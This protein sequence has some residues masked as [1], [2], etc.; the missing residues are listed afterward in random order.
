[1][2]CWVANRWTLQTASSAN[3]ANIKCPSSESP[4]GLYKWHNI[5]LN[6]PLERHQINF[7]F[8]NGTP[9][10]E[11]CSQSQRNPLFS[12]V[13]ASSYQPSVLTA[14]LRPWNKRERAWRCHNGKWTI[15]RQH[16]G[17]HLGMKKNYMGLQCSRSLQYVWGGETF[18]G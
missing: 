5:N 10:K 7:H 18:R 1:M 2:S 3:E 9:E 16:F 8:R 6:I 17:A 11:A 13:Q 15:C 14:T 4:R 12:T